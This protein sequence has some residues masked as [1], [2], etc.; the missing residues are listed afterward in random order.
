MG[1]EKGDSELQ[2]KFHVYITFCH[3]RYIQNSIKTLALYS[4]SH[5]LFSPDMDEC[6]LE[7]DDCDSNATC[8]NTIGSFECECL[9]D[10][11]GDGVNCEGR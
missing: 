2:S 4:S 10:F 11:T 7:I 9:P 5:A 8:N 3:L 6:V 1:V